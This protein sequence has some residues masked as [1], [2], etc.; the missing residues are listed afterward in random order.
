MKNLIDRTGCDNGS[1]GSG[2][3]LIFCKRKVIFLG[4]M[5]VSKFVN[6]FTYFSRKIT[7]IFEIKFF[8][9]Y[10]YSKFKQL[11]NIP[12]ALNYKQ[13]GAQLKLDECV[14]Y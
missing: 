9:L 14:L 3:S 12:P 7:G 11:K 6:L 1:C 2:G 8:V 13:L 4:K 5:Y 10:Q